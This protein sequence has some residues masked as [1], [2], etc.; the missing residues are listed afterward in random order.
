MIGTT[1]TTVM[2]ITGHG[3]RRQPVTG[4]RGADCE[5]RRSVA[6]AMG[7]LGTR[8]ERRGTRR[9]ASG[10]R[11][12]AINRYS[13]LGSRFFLSPVASCPKRDDA[14]SRIG[15]YGERWVGRKRQDGRNW[16][17]SRADGGGGRRSEAAALWAA[18]RS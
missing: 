12:E 17:E 7:F 3:K 2:M 18:G 14:G 4:V 1:V 5:G 9:Q 8:D 11:D 16:G 15:G 13:D 10:V 6:W